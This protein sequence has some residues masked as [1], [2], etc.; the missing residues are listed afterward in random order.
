MNRSLRTGAAASAARAAARASRLGGFGNGSAIGGRVLLGLSRTSLSE[1]ARGVASVLVTGTNGKTTTNHLLA[2]AL[3]GRGEVASN[4]D[5]ANMAEGIAFALVPQARSSRD[6]LSWDR[7]AAPARFGCFE[8]D[9][10]H[11]GAVDQRVHAAVI[12]LLNLSRDQLDRVAEVRK[13]AAG[14][15]AALAASAAT[16]VANADDPLVAWAASSARRV[17]WVAA[18]AGYMLDSA[19]CPACGEQVKRSGAQWACAACGLERPVPGYVVD[20]DDLIG[21]DGCRYG[22]ETQLPGSYN[23]SNAA[24]AAVAAAEL[25]VPVAEAL[26]AMKGATEIAGR[27]ARVPLNGGTG[28]LL[29]AKNPAGWAEVL[30]LVGGEQPALALAGPMLIAINARLADGRDPSWLW[31]VPF[32]LLAEQGPG[33]AGP[34]GAGPA[35]GRT[36]VVATGERCFDLAVRLRY[37]EVT[38]QVVP[39]LVP[40]LAAVEAELALRPP[41]EGADVGLLANY[42]AF[43]QLRRLLPGGAPGAGR[44]GGQPGRGRAGLA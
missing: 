14:W 31:D 2:L 3:R 33:G 19:G 40:A 24:M 1:L 43:Q 34:G 8:V 42:T 29:L 17:V 20:R 22:L 12:V 9:E 13:V 25:G 27:Y 6:R 18:G 32:E 26:A 30:K 7:G 11:M 5:G 35:A 44:A 28:R 15:K 16:V 36:M 41:A 38:H 10:G 37:A 23:G 4:T 21:P 39:G